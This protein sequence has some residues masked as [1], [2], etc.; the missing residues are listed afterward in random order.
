[1]VSVDIDGQSSIIPYCPYWLN[2]KFLPKNLIYNELDRNLQKVH[3][4]PK[5]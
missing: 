5:I 1:M 2:F 4:S 3:L